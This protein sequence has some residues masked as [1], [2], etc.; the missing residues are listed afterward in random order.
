MCLPLPIRVIGELSMR[1]I[2]SLL[3]VAVMSGVVAPQSVEA[4]LFG[5]FKRSS[6]DS[7]APEAT[8]AAPSCCAP[9]AATCCAPAAP[10]CCAPA[11]VCCEPEPC[12]DPCGK[13]RCRLFSGRLLKKLRRKHTCCPDPCCE[14]APVSCCA[15]AAPSCAAPAPAPAPAPPAAAPAAAAAAE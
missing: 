12:C 6:C 14:P 8:C 1:S 2:L 15:P 13:P 3:A 4:G 7:C 9:V 5:H 10:T 11:P